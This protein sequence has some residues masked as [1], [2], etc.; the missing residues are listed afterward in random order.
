MVAATAGLAAV[1]VAVAMGLS[2]A[3]EAGAREAMAGT[4]RVTGR[5]GLAAAAK[6]NKAKMHQAM[7][8]Q[9]G[10]EGRWWWWRQRRR[11]K[12]RRRKAVDGGGLDG[13][14]GDYSDGGGDEGVGRGRG[15]GQERPWQGRQGVA[16]VWSGCDV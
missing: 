4:V 11:R 9:A 3:P 10:Q 13:G 1:E 5:Q 16:S 2:A 12:R 8:V 6:A 7:H 14:G 15:A